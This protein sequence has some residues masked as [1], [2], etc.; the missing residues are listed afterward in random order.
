MSRR[1][2]GV[3]VPVA[4]A[5]ILA[6]GLVEE[7]GVETQVHHLP[8]GGDRPLLEPGVVR[9]EPGAAL[10]EVPD[11]HV[12]GVGAQRQ[13]L[14]R[15]HA[16]PRPDG[17]RVAVLFPE[18]VGLRAEPQVHQRAHVHAHGAHLGY[19]PPQ[20]R[21]ALRLVL[22]QPRAPGAQVHA[23]H[24]QVPDDEVPDPV[25]Q[26][27]PGKRRQGRQ[28]PVLTARE[29]PEVH[30]LEREDAAQVFR[31]PGRPPPGGQPS[32]HPVGCLVPIALVRGDP[33]RA[34]LP[35]AA[36]GEERPVHPREGRVRVAEPFV[37]VAHEQVVVQVD[38]LGVEVVRQA[39][40]PVADLAQ[41]DVQVR[42]AD[43]HPPGGVEQVP[44]VV[45]P[46]VAE[47]IQ[48]LVRARPRSCPGSPRTRASLRPRGSGPRRS[49]A[50]R[51]GTAP[52]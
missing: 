10:V 39:G 34:A 33:D 45:A 15:D 47:W 6:E 1:G 16:V 24:G 32:P 42:E 26:A 31:G 20:L 12:R 48:R 19:R 50:G 17:P 52:A 30:V 13:G 25:L 2:N 44:P 7:R 35:S 49:C 38:G 40:G 37:E 4:E 46:E 27:V 11:D 3:T 29:I 51:R 23:Q 14:G 36:R 9:T 5:V 21:D 8:R 22:E 18:R 41:R 28:G 43:V